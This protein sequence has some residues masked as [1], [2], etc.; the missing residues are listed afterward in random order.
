MRQG[1]FS[2][3]T[4]CG[5]YKGLPVSSKNEFYALIYIF[6]IYGVF[7]IIP[8]AGKEMTTVPHLF[9]FVYSW[10]H[11]HGFVLLQREGRLV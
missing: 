11:S 5:V 2:T 1:L 6:I 4:G 3:Y 10:E 7:L 8:P 9:T